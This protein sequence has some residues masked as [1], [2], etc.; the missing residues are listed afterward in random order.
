MVKISIMLIFVFKE[1]LEKQS[2][3]VLKK[4]DKQISY[5]VMFLIASTKHMAVMIEII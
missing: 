5:Q 2:F 4:K 1:S 3:E